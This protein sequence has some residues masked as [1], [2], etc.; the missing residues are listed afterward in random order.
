M[1]RLVMKDEL[2]DAQVLR[3]AGSAPYGGA[4]LGE[5]LAA[6]RRVDGVDLGRWYEAWMRAADDAAALAEAEL[7]AGR[8]VTAQGCFYR[9]SSYARNAGVMLMGT[10]LDDRL[11]QSNK[12]QT[13]TFRR[14]AALFAN[15]PEAV[16]MP[17]EGTTLPGYYFRANEEQTPGP[18]V[19]LLG[20]YD[21]TAEELYFLNGAAALARGYHVLAFDGPGQGAALIQQGIVL[22]PDFETVVAAA[23]DHL[24]TRPETDPDRI[25]IIGLSLG[26]HLAPR[27]ASGEPRLAAC[28]ADCGSFDLFESA[29]ERVPGPLAEGLRTGKRSSAIVL[30]AILRILAKKPTAGWALRRGQL[31][32]GVGS[33]LAYLESLREYSLAGRAE[34]IQCPTLV[35]NAEGD[36]ISATAPRL[37]EALQCTKKFVT[38]RASEGAGDH[39]EAGA[40]TLYHARSFAWL[41]AIMKPGTS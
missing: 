9:A 21:G 8:A 36:D 38:F 10:P 7:A 34:A 24:L 25:A 31:V 23:I 19:I 5:C 26:A 14:G 11:R 29:L 18:T 39:C 2:L 17:F 13:E 40:R 1:T 32:H 22:R 33:P 3:T 37:F 35:C 12:K 41:D 20:G 6:A 4:D 16:S 28:I 15:P 27:A 30:G